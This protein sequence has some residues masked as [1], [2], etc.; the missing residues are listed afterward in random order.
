MN[1]QTGVPFVRDPE[2]D[3]YII[4]GFD[5]D[6]NENFYFL[7]GKGA[8]L[9]CFSKDGKSLYRKSFP[10]LV[11]GQMHVLGNRIYFFEIGL[12]SLNTLVEIDKNNGMIVQQYPKTIAKV[13]RAYGY[14]QIDYYQFDEFSD[15]ILHITY[16]DSEGN[17]KPKTICFNLKGEL[18][19]NCGHHLTNG[20]GVERETHY[21]HLGKW[22]N[23]YVLGRFDDDD[24]N[25]Y[26]VSLRDS[27]NNEVAKSFVDRRYLGDP[28]CGEYCMPQEHRKVRNGKLYMLNRVKN[29]VAIT[30]IDLASIFRIK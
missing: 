29:M 7:A 6:S 5:I 9:A 12:K 1:M 11:P 4:D 14:Q 17:E 21:E 2:E 16:I 10:N 8:I 18:I 30:E 3:Q 28:M 15:T 20:S 23:D 13:L 25:K 19:A 26:D 27:A 22:G 24:N